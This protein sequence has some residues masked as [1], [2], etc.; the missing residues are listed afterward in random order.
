MSAHQK[1]KVNPRFSFAT[2]FKNVKR[3][4]IKQKWFQTQMKIKRPLFSS[5]RLL[6]TAND[7]MADFM[8]RAG[9][10]HGTR[11]AS[12]VLKLLLLVVGPSRHQQQQRRKV[13][14]A[15]KEPIQNRLYP[16]H[17]YEQFKVGL[18]L[19]FAQFKLKTINVG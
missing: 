11:Q 3:L 10:M 5:T 4:I 16:K 9:H 7:Q 19:I 14:V 17:C 6:G 2:S 1:F 12:S 15:L 13:V 18:G 8:F